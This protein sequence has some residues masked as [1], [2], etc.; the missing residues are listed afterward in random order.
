MQKRFRR[1]KYITLVNLL[2]TDE[3]FPK[4]TT[5][6]DPDSSDEE[7]VLFPEYLTCED[8]SQQLAKHIVS[9]LTDPPQRARL[10]ERLQAL[11]TEV[12]QGG[13]SSTAA[14]YILDQL[15]AR[16]TRQLRPHFM[17]SRAA[18]PAAVQSVAA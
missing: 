2:T 14:S 7:H 16:P 8:K 9:W 10:V 15:A 13:A 1:V 11:K 3:L 4:D 12:A 17:P 18:V 6:Y 5:P